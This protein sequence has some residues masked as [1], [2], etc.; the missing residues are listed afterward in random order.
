MRGVLFNGA[1]RIDPFSLLYGENT[2]ITLGE[3]G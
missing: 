2:C 3:R 1:I